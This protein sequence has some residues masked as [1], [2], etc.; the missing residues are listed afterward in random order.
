MVMAN[1]NY[2]L[3]WIG[4]KYYL[5]GWITDKMPSHDVYVEPFGGAAHV[6][7][8]KNPSGIEIYNDI[9]GDLVNLFKY[10][11]DHKDELIE[12]LE[13]IPYSRKIHDDWLNEWK[14]G[15]KGKDDLE[16]AARFFFLINT[17]MNG[18]MGTFSTSYKKNIT[19]Q[20]WGKVR[21]IKNFANRMKNVIIEN[22]DFEECIKMY[23]SKSTLYYIDPPYYDINYYSTNFSHKDHLRLYNCLKDIEGKFIISYYP[24]PVILKLYKNYNIY[25]KECVKHSNVVH[26]SCE[27]RNKPR[28]TEILITNFK[29]QKTLQEVIK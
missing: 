4:G 20:Y 12:Y 21:N 23:D 5:R 3:S 16:R 6:L 13:M 24:H 25:E 18:K 1:E 8:Y 17:S 29:F 27:N 28:S 9:D 7:L 19:S 22:K 10:A 15:T 26:N 11:R 14:Q 2:I